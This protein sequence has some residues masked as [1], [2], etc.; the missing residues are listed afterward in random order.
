MTAAETRRL[1]NTLSAIAA[2]GSGVEFR[3]GTIRLSA[4]PTLTTSPVTW[5]VM[6]GGVTVTAIWNKGIQPYDGAPCTLALVT[7]DNSTVYYVMWINNTQ[8]SLS[9]RGLVTAFTGGAATCTVQ[10]NNVSYTAH[11][12][13]S[14]T[15]TVGDVA[16]CQEVAG[17]LYAILPLTVYVPP[18]PPP[19]PP[20]PPP[21]PPPQT[22][23]STVAAQ[24][25][26]TW[27]AAVGGWNSYFHQNVYS[28]S[29]YVPPSTGSWFYNGGTYAF[30]G[31]TITSAQFY[32]PARRQAGSYNSG[33]TIH[34]WSHSSPYRGGEPTRYAE[35]DVYVPPY[36]G[37]GWINLPSSFFGVLFSG[38]GISIAGDPYVGFTGVGE[39]GNSGAL[40]VNWSF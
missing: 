16:I 11:R 17:I 3:P 18:A 13:A 15:P 40:S 21:P 39:N 32:L 34:L 33:V 8:P 29:G 4:D 6:S 9:G 5:L 22:G 26:G 30:N 38:G 7:T 10:I 1:V 27:T 36:F 37:G 12:T 31:K 2:P 24:D 20:P 35:T 14:Y 28:G 23:T 25:S 19:A